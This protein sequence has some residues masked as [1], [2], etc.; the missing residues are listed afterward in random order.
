MSLR[1]IL[2]VCEPGEYGVLIYL[3]KLVAYLQEHHKGVSIDYVYSSR[4]GSSQQKELIASIREKGGD[5]LDLNIGNG[6]EMRDI[7]A[8]LALGR[9]IRKTSPDLIHAHSSKAG[10]LSRAWAVFPGW[11]PVLY[12]PHGYYGMARRKGVKTHFFNAL[13]SIFGRLGCTHNVSEYER[14]F[15]I[16][17]LGLPPDRL[18][19]IVSGINRSTFC[20]VNPAQK[21]ALRRKLGLPE[22][23]KLLVTVGRDGYEKNQLAIYQALP[24]ALAAPARFFAHAGWGSSELRAS[25]DPQT[26]DKVFTY[27]YLDRPEELLQAADGFIMTSRSE[28]FGLAAFEALCCGLPLIVTATTGLL[29]LRDLKHANVRWLSNPA[30]V[31]SITDEIVSA[32]EDW[33]IAPE[34]DEVAQVAEAAL[35]FD[36]AAQ[37]D[38]VFALYQ[39]LAR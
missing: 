11:S 4:R 5:T 28:A 29:T 34:T 32:I 26:K 15:G 9:F 12:S 31:N 2:M 14:A 36:E 3:R 7:P 27:S 19:T 37:F 10:I 16:D 13:E 1:R 35:H 18:V 38:K 24:R 25:L 6:P 17:T 8:F 23:G 30:E 22:V 20:P 39:K 21:L 33:A